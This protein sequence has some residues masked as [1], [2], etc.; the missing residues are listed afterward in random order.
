MKIL[1]TQ[2]LNVLK[3]NYQP[4][5]S[6]SSQP[7]FRLNDS[8]SQISDSYNPSFRASKNPNAKD[9][10]KVVDA[11]AKKVGDIA[12]E[13]K[14]ETKKGDNILNSDFFNNLLG[15]ADHEVTVQA[16]ISC[17]IC[18]LFRPLTIMALPNKKGKQDN[19]YASAHSMA[20]GTIG[21]LSTFLISNPFKQG[22]KYAMKKLFGELKEDTLRRFYPNLDIESIWLDKAA[23]KRKPV[24]EWLDRFGR[25]FIKD[26]KDV[27]KMPKARHFA[28]VSESTFKDILKVDV[29]WAAQKGKSF[30]EVVTRDGRK[31]YDAIDMNNLAIV[32]RD[33]A[34][35]DSQF[36]LRDLDRGLVENLKKDAAE[37]DSV[38]AKLNVDSVYKDG[39]V[40]DFRKW[41]TDGGEQFKLDLDSL[42]VSSSLDT[43]D[44][45]PRRSGAIR[46]DKKEQRNKFMSYQKNGVN[47]ELG[48]PIDNDMIEAGHAYEIQDKILTWLPDIITRPF[49]AAGTIALIPWMLKN[50]FH[51]EKSK[52]PASVQNIEQNSAAVLDKE[53]KDKNEAV[54]FK[55]KG[56]KEA[57]AF[58]K[59][60]AKIYGKP[61]YESGKLNDLSDKLTRLPGS[62]TQH[63]QT[64]GALVTSGVYVQQTLTKKDLDPDRKRTLAVNQTLCWV[65]PTIAAYTVDNALRGF[66]KKVEY[67]YAGL[68][69]QKMAVAKM[70]G[71]PVAKLQK[72]LG[73]KLQGVRILASLATFTLIYRYLTPVL[74]TPVANWIGD[75]LTAKK[76]AKAELKN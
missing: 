22:N 62:M 19:M 44:Y 15:I 74:I 20:S 25:V 76:H 57:S 30:N 38:W 5:K 4:T 14:P 26:F 34:L 67:R 75:K 27:D 69:E 18:L 72:N 39:K 35:K 29:D 23:G 7:D 65:V 50:V 28:D 49:V 61:L 56:K 41:L 32:V 71:K 46:F 47:G 1:T 11:V 40:Q 13:A 60:L 73:N 21:L 9:V 55:A 10:K 2:D 53:Q 12:K 36:L 43:A 3:A 33:P 58:T 70:E 6:V 63:L 31:L 37:T 64:L 45:V 68:Q 54:S 59:W 66:T 42:F 16:A 17:I 48:T 52:K 8:K 24:S 51:I